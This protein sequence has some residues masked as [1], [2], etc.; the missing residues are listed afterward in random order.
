[1]KKL[2]L[3]IL[4]LLIFAGSCGAFAAE[5]PACAV[6]DMHVPF[7]RYASFTM[8]EDGMWTSRNTDAARI[9]TE[10]E[11]GSVKNSMNNGVV[12]LI[13]SVRG[14]S[15]RSYAEVVLHVYIF[16]YSPVNV[17]G[18]S[19]VAGGSRYDI[20][21]D[22]ETEK[23]GYYSCER[24]DI[25]L[26][27]TGL[28]MLK[29]ISEEGCSLYIYGTG[30]HFMADITAD[31]ELTA[32]RSILAVL[33]E[34]YIE[35]YNLWNEN[36]ARWP[37]DRKP[38]QTV[39]PDSAGEY[40]ELLIAPF[41]IMD[42]SVRDNVK[43]L[44]GILAEN[45]FYTGQQDGKYGDGTRS[46]VI[47]AQCYY[48]LL[49]TGLPDRTLLRCLAG[50]E[51]ESVESEA[52]S[53]D[54]T[55]CGILQISMDSYWVAER[56]TPTEGIQT[57][58]DVT[59]MNSGNMLLIVEGTIVNTD[60]EELQLPIALSAE[61]V[62]EGKYIYPCTIRCENGGMSYYGTSLIPLEEARLVIYAEIPPAAVDISD[63][64]IIITIHDGSDMNTLVYLLK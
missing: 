10:A 6:A 22:A 1:M 36:A 37:D 18:I 61:L 30:K 29:S 35:G 33:P 27:K 38:V 34:V 40:D 8:D 26:D 23:I 31:E 12:L 25:P 2:I 11:A 7:E 64:E 59:P 16:R 57:G 47:A 55:D 43:L 46:A 58:N 49:Q 3:F 41:D 63:K 17:Q 51:P 42:I 54:I 5:V 39:S 48:G 62:I 19:I 13:P 60:T 45:G 44:Q 15:E 53:S 20:V 52:S 4:S 50:D 21:A 56:L 24:I 14:D 9:L 32:V 28:E